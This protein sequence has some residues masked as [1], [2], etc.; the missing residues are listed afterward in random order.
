MMLYPKGAGFRGDLEGTEHTY[1]SL[2]FNQL[3]LR[4]IV[5]LVVKEQAFNIY[6]LCLCSGAASTEGCIRR[7]HSGETRLSCF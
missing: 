1:V 4:I 6:K 3:K 2:V 5:F 7:R